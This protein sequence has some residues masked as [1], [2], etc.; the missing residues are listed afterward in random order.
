[1]GAWIGVDPTTQCVGTAARYLFFG[2]PDL[3]D[4]HPG[5]VSARA[6]GRLRFVTTMLEEGEERV[7]LTDPE[8]YHHFDP[9]T[10][11]GE[12]RLAGLRV[13]GVPAD[14]EVGFHGAA[15]ATLETEG[16]EAQVRVMADQGHLRA[17]RMPGLER[18]FAGQ[19]ARCYAR[20]WGNTRYLQYLVHSRRRWVR[21][22]V[23]LR[24]TEEERAAR[25]AA[26]EQVLAPT[27]E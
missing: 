1:V 11:T 22:S 18:R 21:I 14:W 15:G 24:G 6:A 23:E 16:M 9:E 3:P 4:S 13:T 12:H 17:D 27:F 8:T 26:L 10:R 20:E 19:P 2:Y 7:D 25:L 5:E